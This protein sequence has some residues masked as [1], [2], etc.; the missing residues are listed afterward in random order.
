MS[1][2]QFCSLKMRLKGRGRVSRGK[3][4]E[5][6]DLKVVS[7]LGFTEYTE[8]MGTCFNEVMGSSISVKKLILTW[9]W[10]GGFKR[11]LPKDQGLKTVLI[12]QTQADAIR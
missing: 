3:G 5:N 8:L 6:R 2:G 10:T 11:L 1:A 9:K 7:K 12:I 4:T